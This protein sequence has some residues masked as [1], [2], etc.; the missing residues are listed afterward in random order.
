MKKALVMMILLTLFAAVAMGFWH[1]KKVPDFR[2]YP[3]MFSGQY[4]LPADIIDSVASSQDFLWLEENNPEISATLYNERERKC[5]DLMDLD[6]V[7]ALQELSAGATM[8]VSCNADTEGCSCR[9]L[10]ELADL[11]PPT[12]SSGASNHPIWWVKYSPEN[13]F[14]LNKFLLMFYLLK[15]KENN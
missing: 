2:K 5:W 4:R 15:Q 6:F 12:E 7:K 8:V 10:Y 9:E 13:E 3:P 1:T 14:V 11:I